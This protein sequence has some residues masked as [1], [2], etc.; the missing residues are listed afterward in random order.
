VKK[1]I[2]AFVGLTHL[3][4]NSA[5]ASAQRGY[6]IIAHDENV[7]RISNLNNQKLEIVEPG[8]EEMLLQNIDKITFTSKPEDLKQADLVYISTDVPTDDTGTSDLKPI[9]ESIQHCIN[10]MR[11]DAILVILCQVHPLFTREI[12]WPRDRLF[13][14]VETLIFGKA[15]DRALNPERFIVGCANPEAGLPDSLKQYLSSFDCPILPMSYESAELT[16]IAINMFLI[17]SVSTTNTLAEVCEKIGAN[18]SEIAPALKLDKRIGQFAYLSPGLGIA[19]GNLERDI[20]TILEL[21]KKSNTHTALVSS[22]VENSIHRKNWAFDTLSEILKSE[23]KDSIKLCI[24]GLT[25]KE[26]THSLK[27][28]A[29]I[30]LINSLRT[31]SNQI[32]INSYDPSAPEVSFKDLNFDRKSSIEEALEGAD[33][34]VVMTPWAEFKKFDLNILIS[35]MR[36][37]VVIDPYKVFNKNTLLKSSFNYYTLGEKAEC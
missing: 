23:N 14:Q 10:Y 11:D 37:K 25:Y 27:N 20:N 4:L 16:K 34:L 8:L 32:E 29:S 22:W 17:S 33:Y 2:V 18:W 13:Y 31:L 24:L 9:I 3:G 35:R 6:Q 15:L 5:I 19:G 21:G 28:S 12:E 30:E 26:D 1:P 36:G 7:G